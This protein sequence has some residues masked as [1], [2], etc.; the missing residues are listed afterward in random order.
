MWRVGIA[1]WIVA[2]AAAAEGFTFGIGSPVASQDFHFKSAPFVFRTLGCTAKPQISATAEGLVNGG[3]RSL[4][5]KVFEGSRP[6]VYA[7][8]QSWQAG[9]TWVVSLKGACAGSMAG[10]IVPFG[11]KGFIR[12]SSRF[13]S[14]PATESEIEASLKALAQ[15]GSK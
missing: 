3:R 13:L 14:H 12:A 8:S 15:G 4:P 10:A 11:P 5:L 9:G 1:A 2:A 7:V 6:G